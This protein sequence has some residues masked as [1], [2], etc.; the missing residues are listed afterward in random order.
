[1]GRLA[2]IAVQFDFPLLKL[3]LYRIPLNY[4]LIR[5]RIPTPNAVSPSHAWSCIQFGNPRTKVCSRTTIGTCN[6][7]APYF[8][9][10]PLQVLCVNFKSTEFIYFNTSIFEKNDKK[11]NMVYWLQIICV[12]PPRQTEL[13]S[14]F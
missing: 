7:R 1:M 4:R 12:V 9:V 6:V 11:K 14:S 3:K 5:P 13:I 8:S 2:Y 10:I